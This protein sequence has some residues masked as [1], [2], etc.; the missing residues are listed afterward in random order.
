[1]SM[2]S[3]TTAY[4]R[5]QTE[6]AAGYGAYNRASGEPSSSAPATPEQI[7]A[8]KAWLEEALVYRQQANPDEIQQLDEWIKWTSE[9]LQA[10]SSAQGA[11]PDQ[12]YQP[13][14]Q[15]PNGLPPDP[16]GLMSGPANN[17]IA[18]QGENQLSVRF[19]DP[20]NNYATYV[21]G[22]KLDLYINYADAKTTITAG[23]DPLTGEPTTIITVTSASTGQSKVFYVMD[24]ETEINV[25]AVRSERSVTQTG[26][27]AN[28]ITVKDF[29]E[30]TIA[31]AVNPNTPT[32]SE[33]ED[34]ALVNHFEAGKLDYVVEGAGPGTDVIYGLEV[35]FVNVPP[36]ASIEVED[37][38]Y[39]GKAAIK[40]TITYADG[41]KKE[42]YV[43]KRNTG[44]EGGQVINWHY[45]TKDQ[46]VN[47]TDD[48]LEA[49]QKIGE[50]ENAIAFNYHGKVMEEE[51]VAPAYPGDATPTRIDDNGYA[52]YD[53]EEDVTLHPNFDDDVNVHEI[54]A[55]NVTIIKESF[56][57][58]VV[59][60][61]SDN[62][63][64]IAVVG[65]N[66]K[67]ET[68]VEYY[69]VKPSVVKS[70]VL[71]FEQDQKM[72]PN[73]PI[74]NDPIIKFAG[75]SGEVEYPAAVTNLLNF[76]K[77]NNPDLTEEK[78]IEAAEANGIT[79]EQLQNPP[80]PP[81]REWLK[82]L[83][84]IDPDFKLASDRLRSAEGNRRSDPGLLATMRD[85]LV[86][87]LKQ[88]YPNRAEQIN[89]APDNLVQGNGA[90]ASEI[91]ESSEARIF[92]FAGAY[93]SIFVQ[94]PGGFKIEESDY[95]TP[96]GEE[97]QAIADTD[98]A[99]AEFEQENSGATPPMIVSLTNASG[100]S[101]E[102]IYTA[103]YKFFPELDTNGNGEISKAEIRKAIA[104]KK[105]P[106]AFDSSNGPSHTLKKFLIRISSP[107]RDN[108]QKYT[109]LRIEDPETPGVGA[110]AWLNAVQAYATLLNILY[111][112]ENIRPYGSDDDDIRFGNSWADVIHNTP[113]NVV[114]VGDEESYAN[115]LKWDVKND[116]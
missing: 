84:A 33:G 97:S 96:S 40:H 91:D 55:K 4:N 52:I 94:S 29:N 85:R 8:W 37:S 28:P 19:P 48:K 41:H 83:E 88:I 65:K 75:E 5:T 56:S 2:V 106:P 92:E 77:T 10:A 100:S 64:I 23:V 30:E 58:M 66:A 46:F 109:E 99:Q 90:A 21:W 98:A 9:Q 51:E 81:T 79:L 112:S 38:T 15:N 93:Y 60:S 115:V 1:M 87:L 12:N 36:S 74:W 80:M 18:N 70:V 53:R 54:T 3:S 57:N 26:D 59:V 107:L 67:G 63:Y 102:E 11:V 25:H 62:W 32:R 6:G 116:G 24:S 71:G 113:G 101:E 44:T 50:E 108:L 82:F 47:L 73:L 68:R 76:L 20:S 35:N 13:S 104:D 69:K 31:E 114:V 22:D 39:N 43:I 49:I 86:E 95:H 45:V 111:P 105:F 89:T 61:K 42:I 110:A 16:N 78:I 7:Q 27:I 72:H 17:Y 103:L 34:D 14:Y